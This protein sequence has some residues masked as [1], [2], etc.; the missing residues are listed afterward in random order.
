MAR[1]RV[2]RISDAFLG[3]GFGLLA[4]AAFL[5]ALPAGLAVTGGE[6]VVIGYLIERRA[7]AVRE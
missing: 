7:V 1:A 3:V 4:A 2:V 6:C 5:V